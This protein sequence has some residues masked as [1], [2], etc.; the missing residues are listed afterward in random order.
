MISLFY[1]GALGLF[2][3]ILALLTVRQRFKTEISLG[4]GDS[5]ELLAAQRAHGNFIEYALI[6]LVLSFALEIIGEVPDL[7]IIIFGDIFLLARISHAYT[8]LGGGNI[9]FRQM[10]IMFSWLVILT[11]SIWAMIISGPMLISN[12]FG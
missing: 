2:A 11:Q 10:G 5:E 3:I 9:I 4:T 1:A 12:L 7:A 6:F 8:L